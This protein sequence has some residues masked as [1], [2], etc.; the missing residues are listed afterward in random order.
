MSVE[1]LDGIV[2]DQKGHEASVIN[3]SSKEE[4]ISYILGDVDTKEENPVVSTRCED[5]PCCGHGPT[6]QGGDGGGCPVTY[7]DGTQRWRCATCGKL[8]EVG[9]PSAICSEC[10]NAALDRENE[11]W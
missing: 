10:M 4:Q 8:M 2:H 5:Y 7:A 3:N 6:S 1:D 9:A 11:G